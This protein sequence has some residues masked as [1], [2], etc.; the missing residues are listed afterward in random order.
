MCDLS[1]E[2]GFTSVASCP[3]EGDGAV[4][5]VD[6]DLTS[7]TW[8]QDKNLLKGINLRGGGVAQGSPTSDYVDEGSCCSTS[9]PA[10]SGG[11]SGG[12]SPSPVAASPPLA[13]LKHPQHVPYDPQVPL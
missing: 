11:S 7:L 8:L 10:D 2:L 12:H 13:R 1:I 6:D 4:R 3:Q 5:A 9:E